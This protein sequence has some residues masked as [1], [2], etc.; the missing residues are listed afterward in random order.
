MANR[1][2][3]SPQYI[4]QT[5]SGST[6]KSVKLVIE[7]PN[8]TVRY[9]LIKDAS[10]GAVST[11]EWAE[12]ARD[13]LNLDIADYPPS[14]PFLIAGLD[15][16]LNLSF[17]N[18]VNPSASGATQVGSTY[19]ESHKGF[20]GYGVFMQGANPSLTADTAAISNY[21]QTT[22]GTKSYTQYKPKNYGGTIPNVNA[23]GSMYYNGVGFNAT[24]ETLDSG[25]VVTV[26]R[27]PSNKFSTDGNDKGYSITSQRGVQ[28]IF[29]NKYG[30]FQEEFFMFKFVEEIKSKRESFQ[31]NTIA[32]NGTYSTDDHTIQDFDIS[33][34]KTYTLSSGFLPEYYNEVF[35]E[36]LL[37]EKVW[38][39]LRDFYTNTFKETPVNIKTNNFTY[40]N[41][42]NEKLI[43]FSFS[44]DISFNYIN[45]IR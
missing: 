31:S 29:I 39:T 19:T 15:I 33:A 45:N 4:T 24:S 35:T 13:Y 5:A 18:N 17:W 28:V 26:D 44:F 1:L 37:S 34:N 23:S 22:G 38:V 42:L 43:E 12:L 3:R 32:S 36:M 2:L 7:I 10:N 30:A 20:D 41:Y 8:G 25:E 21:S 6:I 11:F 40:K 9:T 14:N 16:E 27:I